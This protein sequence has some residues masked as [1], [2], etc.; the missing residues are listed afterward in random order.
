MTT[1]IEN[2]TMLYT[3]ASQADQRGNFERAEMLYME[4]R[5]IFE[6]AGLRHRVDAANIMNAIA[7]MKQ[8]FG[9]FTGALAAAQDGLKVLGTIRYTETGGD[10]SEIRL[11]AWGVIGNTYRHLA[12]YEEAEQILRTALAYAVSIFGEESEQASTARNHLGVLYKYTGRFEEGEQ[13]YLDALKSLIGKHGEIHSFV[14]VI[15][16]NLGGLFHAQGDFVTGETYARLAWEINRQLLGEDHPVTLAD[17]AAYASLL[18]GLER[19]AESEPI[20]VRVLKAFEK[21]YG[22]EHYEIVVNLNNLANVRYA[23]GDYA[24]AE[25]LFQR[26]LE[27]KEKILG[28]D[29][30]DTALTANNL[31]VLCQSLGRLDE[32]RQLFK[33]AV[34]V[35]ES[36]FT[37]DHPHVKMARENLAAV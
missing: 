27:I 14:A 36:K 7:F 8:K 2:A 25:K 29:H 20:Y 31:G 35:F 24:E 13:L 18:D 23:R 22:P 12:R 19:Y 32:A 33:R 26:A 3:E 30:P 17:A 37:E 16:H 9:D 10:E 34:H 4:S 11:Q 15:Y 5:R 21:M 28:L 1:Q 6:H